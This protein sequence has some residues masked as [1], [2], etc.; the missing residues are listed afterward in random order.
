[1]TDEDLTRT[2]LDAIEVEELP[3]VRRDAAEALR[4]AGVRTA[5]DVWDH[6]LSTL[7]DI[8]GVTDVDPYADVCV[9]LGEPTP[10]ERLRNQFQ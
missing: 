6:G 5:L 1:M 8:E 9:L 7:D 4:R 2:E 3:S 10:S